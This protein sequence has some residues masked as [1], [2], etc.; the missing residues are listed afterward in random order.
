MPQNF[1]L[2]AGWECMRNGNGK[3]LF[4]LAS[5][6]LMVKKKD[7]QWR[8]FHRGIATPHPFDTAQRAIE[9]AE[10]TRFGG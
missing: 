9:Y 6:D 3:R 8:L 1:R 5:E 4:V 10:D 2:P 7:G